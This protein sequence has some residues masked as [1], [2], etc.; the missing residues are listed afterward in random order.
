MENGGENLLMLI[1]VLSSSEESDNED[2]L[3]VLRGP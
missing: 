3:N 2:D 1:D